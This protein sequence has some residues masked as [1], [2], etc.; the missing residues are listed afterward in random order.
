[1]IVSVHHVISLSRTPLGNFVVYDV[2]IKMALMESLMDCLALQQCMTQT[3]N[4]NFILFIIYFNQGYNNIISIMLPKCCLFL[5]TI[6]TIN[7]QGQTIA[8]IIVINTR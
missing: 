3:D 1:M 7:S 2:K 4:F 5:S 8:I 6:E